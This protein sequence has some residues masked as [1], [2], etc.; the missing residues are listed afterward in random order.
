MTRTTDLTA[1]VSAFAAALLL[2]AISTIV[3]VGP[4]IVNLPVA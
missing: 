3:S 1:R 2:A 4:A